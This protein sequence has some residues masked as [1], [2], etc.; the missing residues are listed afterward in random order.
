MKKNIPKIGEIKKDRELG[1]EKGH[2]KWIWT[3]CYDCGEKRWVELVHGKPISSRCKSCSHKGNIPG[4]RLLNIDYKKLK[5][6]YIDK[7]W[8]RKQCGDYFGC[9]GLTIKRHLLRKKIHVRGC[10]EARKL[11]KLIGENSPLYGI[12]RSK[13]TK[14][15]VRRARMKQIIPIKDTKIERKIQESLTKAK[16]IYETHKNIFGQPDIFIAPNICIF[17]DGDY[18]HN[19]PNSMGRDKKVNNFLFNNGY[20]ILRFWEHE[21]HEDIERCINI[22]KRCLKF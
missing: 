3:A 16:I 14:E 8:T 4:N 15:K 9:D 18:W 7:E 21:I 10:S 20:K 11:A 2:H 6:L 12:H 17:C 19:L 5:E 22:I 1:R 13:E